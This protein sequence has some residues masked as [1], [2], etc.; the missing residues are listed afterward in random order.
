VGGPDW[1]S[2][3]G[4]IRGPYGGPYGGPKGGGSRFC[5][6]P[7]ILPKNFLLVSMKALD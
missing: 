7:L 1:G 6:D 2:I 4:S 5:T 3:R